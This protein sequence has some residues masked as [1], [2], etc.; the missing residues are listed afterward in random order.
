MV[1]YPDSVLLGVVNW[2]AVHATSLNN[3][4]HLISADNKV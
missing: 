2:F 4:N 3:S 1:S